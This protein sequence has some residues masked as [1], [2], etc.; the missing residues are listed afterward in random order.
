MNVY[1]MIHPVFI[2]CSF[3]EIPLVCKDKQYLNE[4]KLTH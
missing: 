1:A 3:M 2:V 4:N